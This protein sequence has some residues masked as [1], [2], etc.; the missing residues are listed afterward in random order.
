MRMAGMNLEA[1]S[2]YI[3]QAVSM[4]HSTAHSFSHSFSL[5]RRHESAVNPVSHRPKFLIAGGPLSLLQSGF[6]IFIC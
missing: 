3:P 1:Q 6:I 5:Q 2:L 4:D